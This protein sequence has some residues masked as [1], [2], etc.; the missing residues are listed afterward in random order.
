MPEQA[1]KP[2]QSAAQLPAPQGEAPEQKKGRAWYFWPLVGGAAIVAVFIVGLVG[3]LAVAI[4]ADP[5]DAASWVG[6]IRDLFIIVLAMEGMLMG[7]ALIVLILQLAA[8]VNLLQNEL[9]P[10]V[11]NANETVTTV[12][13]TAQ[14]MSQNL[15]E[16][17]IKAGALM[18][19]V[20]GVVRELLRLRRSVQQGRANGRPARED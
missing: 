13:G 16:P 5:D 12:R 20:G 10:I 7:I 14:F 15:V 4:I 19:G 2:G 18:A 17:V 6:I 11:D 3:A 9:Q 1:N 8:L